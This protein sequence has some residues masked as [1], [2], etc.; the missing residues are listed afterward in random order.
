M[1]P[2]GGC[3]FLVGHLG[4]AVMHLEGLNSNSPP[5]V[6]AAVSR[7]ACSNCMARRAVAARQLG[8]ATEARL[9]AELRAKVTALRA[10]LA[11]ARMMVP[12]TRTN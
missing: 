5:D 3:R 2:C 10:F 9:A 4:E 12:R 11:S 1:M 8:Q 7:V 6:L